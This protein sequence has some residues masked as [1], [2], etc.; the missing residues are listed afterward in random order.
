[1]PCRTGRQQAGDGPGICF[2]ATYMENPAVDG[3]WTVKQ[4]MKILS[5]SLSSLPPLPPQSVIL[6]L[7]QINLLEI[8]QHSWYISR[9]LNIKIRE[10]N[11]FFFRNTCKTGADDPSPVIYG[12]NESCLENL[13]LRIQNLIYC[14]NQEV[15]SEFGYEK[16]VFM[17]IL[18]YAK[19]VKLKAFII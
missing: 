19:R 11:L 15:D 10:A 5:I 12:V 13:L 9:E 4:P 18:K 6:P 8:I 16:L 17:L 7:K 1:M 14:W 2:P 3:V